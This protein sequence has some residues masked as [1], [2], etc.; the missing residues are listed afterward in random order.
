M[1]VRLLTLLL[2]CSC[3]TADEIQIKDNG[4][5]WGDTTYTYTVTMTALEEYNEWEDR[6]VLMMNATLARRKGTKG[7]WLRIVCRDFN[8][9]RFYLDVGN[10]FRCWLHE[11]ELEFKK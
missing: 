6:Q 2:L 9:E 7:V 11:K 10:G 4:D 8:E 1:G 5:W 3:S